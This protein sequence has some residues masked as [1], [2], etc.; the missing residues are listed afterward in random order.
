MWNF[1]VRSSTIGFRGLCVGPLRVYFVHMRRVAVPLRGVH[2][3]IRAGAGNNPQSVLRRP[4]P[5]PRQRVKHLL[6]M[7]ERI[8]WG[9]NNVDAGEPS[10]GEGAK[11]NPVHVS[12]YAVH[13]GLCT[14]AEENRT[15]QQQWCCHAR[16]VLASKRPSGYLCETS[17][18]EVPIVQACLS[19]SLPLFTS[20][21]LVCSGIVLVHP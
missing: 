11:G 13:G 16:R 15:R 19:P 12:L 10:D 1:I 14:L 21:L 8:D 17:K 3:I 5:P 2:A 18:R 4:L 20:W 7:A 9:P 6:R